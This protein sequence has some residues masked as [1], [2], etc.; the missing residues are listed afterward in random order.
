MNSI[1]GGNNALI[2]IDGLQGG[3]LTSLNPNDIESMEILK[4]ASATAI[5]GSRGANGVILITTKS[6]K[7]GKP[8]IDYSFSYGSQTI[9]HKLDLMNAADYAITRN[10]DKATQNGSG[11]PDP[12]FTDAR[13]AELKASGGTDWQDVIYRTAPITNHQLS[14][15]G[16]TENMRYIV[17]GGYL[18]QQGI[19]V[20]SAYK[21]FTLRANMSADINKNVSFG[22]NWEAQKKQVIRRRMVVAQALGFLGQAVNI[23]PRWDPT[24]PPYDAEGN[25]S[26]HPSEYGAYDTWN[27]LAA[28]RE[29]NIM[30]NTISNNINT[31]L[32]LK[33][34]RG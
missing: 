17:S 24:T 26:R 10:A 20:N 27:P 9:R 25:Y 7:K 6:G 22:L 15:S 29:P 31:Y 18:D 4:D 3:N 19:L 21:R 32:D 1:N 16:G 33:L 2:V 14:I 11:V 23:A 30:N 8:T 28:A 12:I 5:Y 34:S 13:I